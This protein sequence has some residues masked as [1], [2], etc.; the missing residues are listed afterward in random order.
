[1]PSYSLISF[2]SIYIPFYKK[3]PC[4]YK[5]I[6]R[7]YH[8]ITEAKNGE[9]AVPIETEKGWLHIAHGVRNTAAGLRYVLYAYMSDLEKPWVVTAQPGGLLLGPRGSERVGDVSNVVFSNGCIVRGRDV[10][11]YYAG[12]DTRMYVATTTIDKLLDYC[13]NT[14]S[15]P[16]R[17]VLCVQKRI[18]LIRKNNEPLNA[19]GRN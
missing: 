19:S 11:L 8:T 7:K 1:M 5:G 14:P 9:G 2:H 13:F 6:F 16:G 3:C 12:S 17:S 10:Y 18:E 4:L 15:D